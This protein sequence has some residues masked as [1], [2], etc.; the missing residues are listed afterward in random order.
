M[1][2]HSLVFV[3]LAQ[4]AHRLSSLR[5]GSLCFFSPTSISLQS[6]ALNIMTMLIIQGKSKAEDHPWEEEE[7]D[8]E[9]LLKRRME[10]E[11]KK[12]MTKPATTDGARGRMHRFSWSIMSHDEHNYRCY[13][14][15]AERRITGAKF[16]RNLLLFSI[17]IDWLHNDHQLIVFPRSNSSTLLF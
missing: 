3:Y 4:P 15:G 8:D 6:I 2:C 12:K 13:W 9:C 16:E 17:V 1:C 11:R 10:T 14:L 5:R 7:D